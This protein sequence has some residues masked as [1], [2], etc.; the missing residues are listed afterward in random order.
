VRKSSSPTL[1]DWWIKADA[2]DLYNYVIGLDSTIIVNERVK[3]DLGLGDFQCP[4]QT[5]PAAPLSR[6]WETCQTMNSA[7][8]YDASKESLYR[9]AKDLIR[10]LV[11]TA[12][13][14]GNYLLNIGPKGDGT[15]TAGA[16]SILNSFGD[17]MKIY[18]E[19]I[20]GTTRSP[21]SLEPTW[22]LYTKKQGK[23]YIHVFSWPSNGILK[24]PS[25][26]NTINK[27]C[28]LNDTSTAISYVDSSGYLKISLP[29]TAPSTINSVIVVNVSGTPAASTEHIKVTRITI[30]SSGGVKTISHIGGTLQLT[31]NVIPSNA[32]NKTVRWALSDTTL[33]SINTGGLLTAKKN[34]KVTVYAT[35][36]DGSD[37]TTKIVITVDTSLA[38]SIKSI[39]RENTVLIVPNPV[40]GNILNLVSDKEPLNVCIYDIIGNKVLEK[41]LKSSDMK[42]NVAALNKGIYILKANYGNEIITQKF[43]KN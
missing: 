39:T 10:E 24:I 38:N 35:A 16:T 3:R 7:W 13:R 15:V 14:D 22:G 12:S 30:N 9:P 21:F 43:D 11:T 25:L 28:L 27:V 41:K 31:A 5:I 33:A 34:G 36:D 23:L 18:S 17:W 19:S 6:Q 20:Y 37:I 4:E 1:T 26:S 32:E 2:V 8:G 29:A 40:T 42:L